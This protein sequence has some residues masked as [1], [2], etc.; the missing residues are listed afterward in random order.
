MAMIRV[1]SF[2]FES[3]TKR[4]S[5]SV[6]THTNSPTKNHGSVHDHW[7]AEVRTREVRVCV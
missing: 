3:K 5:M 1:V 2:I 6:L 7:Y 4:M